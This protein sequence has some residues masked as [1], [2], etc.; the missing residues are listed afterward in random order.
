MI[1]L[2]S[3]R[4]YYPAS[5]I[6]HGYDHIQRVWELA[7]YLTEREKAD[8]EIVQ[9]AVLFHDAQPPQTNAQATR[10]QH[11][12]DSATLAEAFLHKEGWDDQRISAVTHCIRSHRF[13]NSDEKPQTLEAKILFDAD[14]LD[15]IGAVGVAR[16]IGYAVQHGQPFFAQPSQQFREEG[17]LND[18]E[19]HSAYHEY[20]YKLIQLKDLLFTPSAQQLAQEKHRIMKQF[21]EHLLIE[22]EFGHL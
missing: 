5:D 19:H 21:F 17:I 16:A 8:W 9:A 6:V 11:Q 15:A 22:C 2:E 13:R 7:K 12:S 18:G 14:K 1:S 4:C 10:S 20:L 3:V